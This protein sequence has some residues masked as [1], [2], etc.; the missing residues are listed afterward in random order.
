MGEAEL[1]EG[2]EKP[3]YPT[4]VLGAEIL[5]NPF[6]DMVKKSREEARVQDKVQKKKQAPKRK[7]NK[8]LMSFED[9]EEDVVPVVKKA[10]FNTKLVSAGQEEPEILNNAPMPK[11]PPKRKAEKAAVETREPSPPQ[12]VASPPPKAKVTPRALSRSPS[13]QTSPEPEVQRRKAKVDDEIA[14]LK[15]SLR[16]SNPSAPAKQ[17]K[18]KSALEAMVP[19]TATRGR[20][21]KPVRGGGGGDDE[22][23]ALAMFNAFKAKLDSASKGEKPRERKTAD[24]G[25]NGIEANGAGPAAADDDEEA[26]LCDLHFIVDCQSCNAWD[27][28]QQQAGEKEEEEDDDDKAWMS[29]SL[30][31]A[32][33]RLGK[34]LEWKRKNEEELVVIDPREKA[35]EL[36]VE[37]KKEWK[38]DGG[39][40]GAR[41]G[42][43]GGRGGGDRGRGRE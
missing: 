32:K 21:R 18:P 15:A 3:L 13:P 33:D 22:D 40:G 42:M 10:K 41:S 25:L 19:A 16:R 6:A 5:V 38:K 39:G 11:A 14:A 30:S 1:S 4:K 24:T 20:K 26:R 31:F 37:R 28:Q 7:A 8:A 35:V 43:R 29:H 34:D 9:E 23:A 27:E 2:S 17:E 36:G 12:R